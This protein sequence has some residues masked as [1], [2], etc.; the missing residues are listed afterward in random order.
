M[1]RAAFLLVAMLSWL[2][3]SSFSPQPSGQ[4]ASSVAEKSAPIYPPG[5]FFPE[6]VEI[7]FNVPFVTAE[8]AYGAC[9]RA[10][11]ILLQDHWVTAVWEELP[12]SGYVSSIF[13]IGYYGGTREFI[14]PGHAIWRMVNEMAYYLANDGGWGSEIEVY[15]P[16]FYSSKY[17]WDPS[18]PMYE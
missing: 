6:G 2:A 5:Y 10:Q 17:G 11:Q 9:L 1:K 8:S 15:V 4:D 14:F 16:N 3:F 12:S 7:C 13:C 18:V